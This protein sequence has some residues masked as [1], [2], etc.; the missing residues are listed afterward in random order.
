MSKLTEG[1]TILAFILGLALVAAM[2]AVWA[3]AVVWSV[4]TLFGPV[5]APTFE[6]YAA[7]LLLLSLARSTFGK[8]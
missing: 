5:I 6:S 4:N 1:E 8:K 2:L 3:Y 7:V